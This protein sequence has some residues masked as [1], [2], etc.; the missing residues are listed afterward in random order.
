M[1][2]ISTSPYEVLADEL[3]A[4]A[5]RIEREAQFRLTA[6]IADLERR[7]I[8]RQLRIERLERTVY[9]RLAILRDGER[10]PPGEP[11]RTGSDGAPGRDGSAGPPG[12]AGAAG[13]RGRDGQDGQKGDKGDPGAQGP[14]GAAGEPGKDGEGLIGP[15]GPKGDKGDP[16]DIGPAGPAGT[17]GERGKDGESISGPAGPQGAPGLQGPPGP[18]GP[19]GK[20]PL[21]KQWQADA[22]HYQ[23]DV[24]VHET[25]T[26]QARCDTARPLDSADWICL[27]RSGANGKDGRSLN[28]CETWDAK[29]D[30]A[31]LDVV[32]VDRSWFVAKKDHPGPCPGPDWKA[33]PA[34]KTGDKGLRGHQGEKGAP[35][36]TIIDW[37]LD[38][39]SY[40]AVPI[41][42]NGDD[43]PPLSLRALFEQFE[44]EIR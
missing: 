14:A 30:Y 22:I 37:R 26:F 23:G 3:G 15:A 17:V 38:R 44:I 25:G 31:A 2:A 10:G 21:V 24:V 29:W 1:A 41:M 18:E 6:A 28:I 33:G 5:A 7:D 36:D 32:T 4:V 42:S 8:E 27:A 16:G 34:G 13:E 19:P 35:G 40:M 11:G 20:L 9:E 12:P 39:Q 43:G